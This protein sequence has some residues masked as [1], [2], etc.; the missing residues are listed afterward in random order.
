MRK[1]AGD[2]PKRSAASGLADNPG[3]YR[4]LRDRCHSLQARKDNT[5]TTE[6]PADAMIPP[7]TAPTPI[8][9]WQSPVH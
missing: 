1:Q 9:V 8:A 2:T 7:V 4:S 3:T 6:T 5:D